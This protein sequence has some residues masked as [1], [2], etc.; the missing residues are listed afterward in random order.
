MWSKLKAFLS[1]ESGT[2]A[3]E[4]GLIAAIVSMAGFGAIVQ[5]GGSL[6][7]LFGKVSSSMG[8]AANL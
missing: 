7:A 3:V 8:V 2:T 5:M 4:Y 1:D 6:L